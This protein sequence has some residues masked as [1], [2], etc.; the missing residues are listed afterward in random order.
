MAKARITI[1]I[2]EEFLEWLD[3][4]AHAKRCSRSEAASRIMSAWRRVSLEAFHGFSFGRDARSGNRQLAVK[5]EYSKVSDV[6]DVE[7]DPCAE[8]IYELAEKGDEAFQEH[9]FVVEYCEGEV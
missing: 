2:P 6:Y 1:V 8:F 4:Y 5:P 7:G 9:G 3:S